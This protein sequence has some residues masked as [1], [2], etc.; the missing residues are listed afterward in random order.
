MPLCK[1]PVSG[2]R[3]PLV[4]SGCYKI[5]VMLAN[6]FHFSNLAIV[7]IAVF[8]CFM[9]LQKLGH[10][11]PVTRRDLTQDQLFPNLALKEVIDNFLKENPWAED[12]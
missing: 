6:L 4:S 2:P 9:H 1:N 8:V 11:D 7:N 12:Y 5:D 10:F 3:V